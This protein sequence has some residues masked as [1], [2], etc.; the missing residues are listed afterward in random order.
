M[1]TD[2]KYNLAPAPASTNPYGLQS[3]TS[4]D[5]PYGLSA[6]YA[7]DNPY[8]LTDAPSDPTRFFNGGQGEVRAYQPTAWD[9]IRSLFG[10]PSEP[11]LNAS[12][13][14]QAVGSAIPEAATPALAAAKKY[15]VDP[16]NRAA[17]AGGD[18]FREAGRDVVTGATLLQ[19][20]GDYLNATLPSPYGPKP[21]V[22][23]VERRTEREHPVALGVAG[24]VGSVVGS[25]L[26]DPRNWPF[27]ASSAARPILQKLI[28]GGFTAQMSAQTYDGARELYEHWDELKPEERAELGAKTGVGALF[29]AKGLTESIG[30]KGTTETPAH[31]TR[32]VDPSS[33]LGQ[34]LAENAPSIRVADSDAAARALI[35]KDTVA[36]PVSGVQPTN[37]EAPGRGT[38]LREP[39]SPDA[40]DSGAWSLFGAEHYRDLTPLQQDAVVKSMSKRTVGQSLQTPAGHEQVLGEAS[41]TGP[42]DTAAFINPSARVVSA[43]HLP[44][45]PYDAVLAEATHKI[46]TN[47]DELQRAGVD[48]TKITKPADIDA[49]LQRASDVIKSGLD[50]RAEA[51]ITF[52]AQTQ[53]AADLGMSVEQLLSRKPGEAFNTEQALA[54]RALLIQ[55]SRHVL[56]LARIAAQSGNAASLEAATT[57]IAQHQ[58]IQEKVAGITAEAGRALGGF[59]I[60]KAALPEAKIANVLSKLPPEARAEAVRLLSKFDPTDPQTVRKLGQFVA[61][62]KPATTM[63]KL[64]EFYRNSLLSSPHTIIVKT[65]SEASMAALEAMKKVVAGG[66]SKVTAQDRYFAESWYYAKGMVQAL[67]EHAKPILTGEFQL[68]GSPGFEHAGQQAIKGVTGQVVRAPSEAMSRMT[69]LIYAGNYFGELNALAARRAIVEGLNGDAFHA[70]QEYLSHHP[71]DDM[72]EAAH[73]LATTN[74]FQNELTGVAKKAGELVAAKPNVSWLPESMKS[75]TP[76]RWLFPFFKTPVNLLKASLTHATPYE[77]LNGLINHDP[78]ALARGVLGSSISA[79]IAYL[80]LNGNITGGGPT[81]YKKE[82]TKRATGWQ[83]YSIKLG[84]HY[85]SYKRFEPL[86]LTTGLIADAIHG[87][88]SGDSEVVAQ[89]KTDTAVKHVMRNLDD[90][91]FMGTLANLLQAVHDPVGGR[92]QSFINREAGSIIPAGVANIAETMDPTI[93]RPQSGMQAV[94]SRIPGL[95]SAA[96]PIIDITGKTVQRPGSNLGGANPF[97]FT[98]AKHD[99][100]VDELARLGISTPQPPTQ[101]K[102]KG[103]PTPLTDA[104]RQQFAQ[105][106]GQAIYERMGRLIQSGSWQR[107]TDDQKR[108]ALV[109]LH[110]IIDESRP[111]RLTRM[112]S[113]AAQSTIQ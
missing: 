96:P 46:I 24:G 104:E 30:K 38:E 66:L 59:N 83:P 3:A 72:Q 48:V 80:A 94:E 95:T 14:A 89:S 87:N 108:K 107:R 77:L 9:K 90:M 49:V 98:T 63:D 78:D 45:V 11:G 12:P 86:G 13:L 4:A 44:V 65:A 60:G 84:D 25:T 99:P 42:R 76:G 52:Q 20:G 109:E 35:E 8:G 16:L 51:T 56:D 57:A 22:E 82:E 101:I 23:S 36:R 64:F 43:N 113:G 53:L 18:A 91:P 54:A 62:V 74:T 37:V 71:T 106:E 61:K 67:A 2:N 58:A 70:R 112:R 40:L 50:E 110:R 75:V 102:W 105:A 34:V 21:P 55:S 103:K 93:R 27:L 26:A 7:T 28:A 79:A 111:A 31:I 88:Q 69:N 29:L 17:Q 19:H 10:K 6:T 97:P 73:K 100:V 32:A 47:S 68:E 85:F 81:D 15:A 5:N 39:L 33:P 92:A 1:P 41:V